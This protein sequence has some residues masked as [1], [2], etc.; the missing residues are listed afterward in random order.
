MKSGVLPD[1]DRAQDLSQAQKALGTC[2]E[3]CP[4]FERVEREYQKEADQWEVYPNSNRIDPLLAVKIYRRPAAGREVALPE[5]IR[6][7]KVLKKTLDYLLHHL[8]PRD[9]KNPLF[10]KVQPFLWNRTRA[11]RQD[12]IVQS[13]SEQITIECHERIARMH[14]L[15][16]HWKGGGG[17]GNRE[18]G[19]ENEGWSEQQELEQLRKSEYICPSDALLALIQ[20]KAY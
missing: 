17:N 12:F 11:I 5:D 3:M 8:L 4:E 16:L 15:Y 6:P 19:N 13:Q 7:P 2:H 1:P 10:S 9:A 14:I 18:E 20:I